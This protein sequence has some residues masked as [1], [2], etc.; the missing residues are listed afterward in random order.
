M[1]A[2]TGLTEEDARVR[3]R[4]LADQ[5][6]GVC[7]LASL[8]GVSPSYVSDVLSGRRAPGPRFLAVVGLKK[9]VLYVPI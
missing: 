7:A 8:L 4:Q 1:P 6:G 5:A 9:V 3:I 2:V